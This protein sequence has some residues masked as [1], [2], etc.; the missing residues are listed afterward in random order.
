MTRCRRCG[1]NKPR[2]QF[3][4][5]SN[6]MPKTNCLDC[7]KALER[8]ITC[9]K[10]ERALPVSNFPRP[11]RRSKLPVCDHCDPPQPGRRST[12]K[13]LPYM[14]YW[15]KGCERSLAVDWFDVKMMRGE[16]WVIGDCRACKREAA[17]LERL[18]KDD[19]ERKLRNDILYD[20]DLARNM[21]G[22][23]YGEAVAWITRGYV[24]RGVDESK[25]RA[26]GMTETRRE[27]WSP[28]EC[29]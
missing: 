17:E 10:C 8:T 19:E 23:S 12:R 18:G 25:L 6:R 1:L 24:L 14:K 7:E 15:C 28:D 21:F 26:W 29:N 20:F 5:R 4:T 16:K 9:V 22:M 13:V 11:R 3:G 2:D 27:V